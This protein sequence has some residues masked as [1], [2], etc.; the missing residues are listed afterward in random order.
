MKPRGKFL[1]FPSESP[2]RT[3]R[4]KKCIN[5][6]NQREFKCINTEIVTSGIVKLQTPLW[7][8]KLKHKWQAYLNLIQQGMS[9][10][11]IAKELDISI[12]TSFDWRHKILNSLESLSP[13][14]LEG[15]VE[16]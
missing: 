13:K 10:K 4:V 15:T 8:I 11:K 7:D 12:Q 5:V 16:C 1:R 14:Q 2:A 3:V 9:I 6:E